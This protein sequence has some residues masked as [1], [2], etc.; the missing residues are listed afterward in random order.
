MRTYLVQL[1]YG[2]S[3][4]DLALVTLES[5]KQGLVDLFF[6]LNEKSKAVEGKN[7]VMGI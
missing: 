4:Q 5:S 1:F 7:G 2:E 6:R 3:P